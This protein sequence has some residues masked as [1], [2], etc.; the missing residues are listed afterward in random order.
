[1]D[2]LDPDLNRLRLRLRFRHFQLLSHAGARRAASG[3]PRRKCV[4]QPALEPH[5]GRN[6]GR[7][8]R[9]AVQRTSRGLSPTGH[10][11]AATRSA[12]QILEELGRVP[13]EINL[14]PQVAALIRV[15]APHFVAH[16]VMPRVISRLA[17]LRPRGARIQ[18][19]E[20]PVPELFAA[21][22]EGDADALVNY[23]RRSTS[24]AVKMPLHQEKLY[25]SN[26]QLV[27]PRTIGSPNRA[28]PCRWRNWSTKTGS[29]PRRTRC[30][31][32]K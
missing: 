7:P 30:C 8:G 15:G 22:Q 24:E 17:A 23:L 3:L 12:R 29:C 19:I 26:Y 16:S 5:A 1:M 28:G 6:R 13:Q 2:L 21:L 9:A 18:L 11:I 31:A 14:G 27:A 25:E 32:R 20:R 10:G 4:T